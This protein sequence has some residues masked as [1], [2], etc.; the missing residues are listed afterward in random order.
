[1]EEVKTPLGYDTAMPGGTF[2]KVGVGVLRKGDNASYNFYKAY[3]VVDT[4]KWSVRRT[5]DSIEFSQILDSP[6]SEYK[7]VFSKT[8][9]LMPDQPRMTIE[10][11]LLNPGA[12]AIHT[13]LY[14]HTFS[15]RVDSGTIGHHVTASFPF[16]I[17]PT[18]T[19]DPQF[20]KLD[21]HR[22]VYLKNLENR[23]EVS[24]GIEGFGSL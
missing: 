18:S 11:T 9:R 17:K 19:P 22:L 1:V 6:A 14:N 21:A 12:A 24:A 4:G 20:A 15:P 16:E 7:Y 8:M 13:S 5:D 10:H 2:V 3:E 23:D